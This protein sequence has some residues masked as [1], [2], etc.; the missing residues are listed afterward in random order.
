MIPRTYLPFLLLTGWSVAAGPAVST[1]SPSTAEQQQ[2][3][4]HDTHGSN[5][6]HDA[7]TGLPDIGPPSTSSSTESDESEK[8]AKSTTSEAQSTE[9]SPSATPTS[10][11]QTTDSLDGLVGGGSKTTDRGEAPSSHT[12]TSDSDSKLLPEGSTGDPLKDI[13]S[14]LDGVKGLLSPKLL[15]DLEG[16]VHDAAHLLKA[17]T[18]DDTKTLLGSA[19]QLLNPHSVGKIT[20][21]VHTAQDIITPE[22]IN[23]LKKVHLAQ[24]FDDIGVLYTKGKALL[25]SA[26]GFVSEH[27]IK[28]VTDI[29]D[30]VKQLLTGG[31]TEDIQGILDKVEGLLP[32]EVTDSLRTVVSNAG[33]LVNKIKPFITKAE[34]YLSHVDWDRLHDVAKNGETLIAGIATVLTPEHIHAIEDAIEKAKP[35]FE[36]VT[37][38]LSHADWSRLGP[39]AKSGE[40][41]ISALASVVTPEN[42]KKLEGAADSVKPYFD[43]AVDYLS[44]ANWDHLGHVGSSVMD[45]IEAIA[46]VATPENIKKVGGQVD[47]LKP[48][49]EKIF[50]YL[51]NANWDRLGDLGNSVEDLIG[52][53]AS[54][55]TP[56]NIKKLEGTFN[57]A[58]DYF[59]PERKDKLHSLATSVWSNITPEGINRAG[60]LLGKA[61]DALTPDLFNRTE[62]VFDKLGTMY[63]SLAP[64]ITPSTFDRL[65]G[66]LDTVTGLLTPHFANETSSLIGTASGVLTPQLVDKVDGLWH[67]AERS[68]TPDVR[69]Q[70]VNVLGSAAHILPN[71]ATFIQNLCGA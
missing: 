53:I 33:P 39:L 62:K 66:L 3:T 16:L 35:Y 24:A 71:I 56:E 41:L 21:A 50:N 38:Y 9:S 34:D 18:A 23:E 11:S 58:K 6:M 22:A 27:V 4:A 5:S 63:D 57:D 40:E 70:T 14:F 44:H 10:V 7:L 25:G 37:D 42:I 49:A 28:D 30:A 67:H 32:K 36:K 12:S 60:N 69:N 52:T 19:F 47:K 64:G 48:Y 15:P 1:A 45:L 61:N 13:S 43:K 26:E 31:S 55:V 20:S 17:P 46:S 51:S 8:T 29:I 65:G 68:F 54:V 2:T 59:T